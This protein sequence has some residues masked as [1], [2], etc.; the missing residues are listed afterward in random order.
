MPE[1]VTAV[2]VSCRGGKLQYLLSGSLLGV[3]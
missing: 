3:G 2:K 1:I